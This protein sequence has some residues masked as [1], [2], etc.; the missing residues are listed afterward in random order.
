MST[1]FYVNSGMRLAQPHIVVSDYRC[2]I[3][4]LAGSLTCTRPEEVP[5]GCNQG[6]QHRWVYIADCP[7]HTPRAL[8]LG[9]HI[10]N[11]CRN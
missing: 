10:Y 9:A 6:N 2:S 3:L 8:P 1:V 5:L 4:N 11:F 7:D